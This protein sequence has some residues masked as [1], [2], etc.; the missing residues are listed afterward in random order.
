MVLLELL[1]TFEQCVVFAIGDLRRV[2]DVI[3]FVVTSNLL[4]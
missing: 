2:V 1:Q 3:K 4:S